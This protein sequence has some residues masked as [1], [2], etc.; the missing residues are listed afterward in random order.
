MKNKLFIVII[1]MCFVL[2]GCAKNTDM[3]EI[4]IKTTAYPIEYITTYLYSDYADA[5]GSIYPDDVDINTYELT[6]KQIK[7]FSNNDM[8]IY[9]GASNEPNYA[10]K[11]LNTNQN[12][13][14]SEKKN[15]VSYQ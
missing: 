12:I 7:D 2:T 1:V 11:L 4:K 15:C 3:K 9:N 13:N 8:F 10:I 14:G 6:N 5:I